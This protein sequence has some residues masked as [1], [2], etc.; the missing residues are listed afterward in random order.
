[1]EREGR[2]RRRRRRLGNFLKGSVLILMLAING[3]L[4]V[5]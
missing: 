3:I 4:L 1:M 2:R 5:L